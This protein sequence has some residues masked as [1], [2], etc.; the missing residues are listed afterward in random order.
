MYV[1]VIVRAKGFCK[2]RVSVC[3]R[4]G[5]R[6]GD[7]DRGRERFHRMKSHGCERERKRES[8][9]ENVRE[10]RLCRWLQIRVC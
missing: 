9:R 3:E 4:E 1:C 7:K 6:E 5:E 8:E 2:K 10:K